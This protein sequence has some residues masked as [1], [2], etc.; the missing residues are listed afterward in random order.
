MTKL[1]KFAA[2]PL[3]ALFCGSGWGHCR[4]QALEEQLLFCICPV[5][6]H[7]GLL[8]CQQNI[9]TFR[10]HVNY[11]RSSRVVLCHFGTVDLNSGFVP[12]AKPAP[13]IKPICSRVWWPKEM[14]LTVQQSIV[15]TSYMEYLTKVSHI[16][17]KAE[18]NPS[19][20]FMTIFP[21]GRYFPK[22]L[23]FCHPPS[24]VIYSKAVSLCKC[25]K[26]FRS[27]TVH[28]FSWTTV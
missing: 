23:L 22:F 2:F 15:I 26:H 14:F 16:L 27:Y 13:A 4:H 3:L 28:T 6:V 18:L 7:F 11:L 5:K 17:N 1:R 8:F 9:V 20:C 12:L 25:R 21:T 24:F 19:L 10:R